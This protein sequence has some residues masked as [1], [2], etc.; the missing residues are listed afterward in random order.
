M[1]TAYVDKGI[2]VILGEFGAM[3]RT[4]YAGA[5]A[6]RLAWDKYIARSAWTHGMVPIYWDAGAAT[7][8]H[9]MG[10]FNRSTGAQVYPDLIKALVDAAN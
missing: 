9:S 10:L 4:E 8:N 6:Y 7:D 2:P 3:R 1:K 5:E